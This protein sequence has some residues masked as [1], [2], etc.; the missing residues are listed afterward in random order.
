MKKLS[1][2]GCEHCGWLDE[3][4]CEICNDWSLIGINDVIDGNLYK[5]VA[6]NESKDWESGMVDSYDLKLEEYKQ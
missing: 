5:I 2:K 4:L 6:C 3:A 1:C